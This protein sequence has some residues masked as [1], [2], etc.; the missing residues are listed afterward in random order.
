MTAAELENYLHEHIP[1]SR[2]MGVSVKS[3]RPG[4][5]VLWAPLQPNINHRETAFGGSMSALAILAAWSL[6]HSRLQ[7]ERRTARLV[8]QRNT[9]EYESP[10]S[11]EF[12][13]IAVLDAEQSW[14]KF[15]RMLT[16]KGRARITVSALVEHAGQVAGRFSGEFVA[17]GGTGACPAVSDHG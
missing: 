9:M 8:I 7:D 12:L 6:L 14:Q 1:L 3:V 17:I 15:L 5:A 2:A 16:L 13:A 10:V 11:G 4:R